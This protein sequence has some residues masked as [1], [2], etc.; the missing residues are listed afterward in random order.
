MRYAN[1]LYAVVLHLG[2]ATPRSEKES[3]VLCYS[4]GLRS[5]HLFTQPYRCFL[6]PSVSHADT[7]CTVIWLKRLIVGFYPEQADSNT[8]KVGVQKPNDEGFSQR[9]LRVISQRPFLG[10]QYLGSFGQRLL[11][12]ISQSPFLAAT[13]LVACRGQYLGSFGQRLLRVGSQ[14]PF[15]AATG[16][17]TF[18]GQYLGSFR[19][20]P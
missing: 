1:V 3:A 20:V 4:R 5:L 15:L 16:L 6:E 8:L 12:V 18:R 7:S 17:G 2:P 9:L 14:S 10:G 13:G 11:R 19:K